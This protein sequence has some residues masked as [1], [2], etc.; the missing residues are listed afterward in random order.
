MSGEHFNRTLVGG[1]SGLVVSA[2]HT[3][4]PLKISGL[5]GREVTLGRMEF[6][7]DAKH[8]YLFNS[9]PIYSNVYSVSGATVPALFS[10]FLWDPGHS[11]LGRKK[12]WM[13]T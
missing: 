12:R 11:R 1:L 7:V 2:G 8:R 5:K 13:Q 4:K 9:S 6:W 3:P 10:Q